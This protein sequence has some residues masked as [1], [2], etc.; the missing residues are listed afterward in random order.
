MKKIVVVIFLVI[1]SQMLSQASLNMSL[2]FQWED[3]SITRT[4]LHS[5]AYNEVWGYAA[6]G[7]EYA[8]IGSTRGTHIFDVTDP[9]N[10]VEV[11]FIWGK[12]TGSQI[13]HRDYHDYKGY[14]YAVSDEGNASLQIMD[15]SY[16]PDSVSVV[17]D[18][19]LP[20]KRA[21]NIFIDSA[22][23][24]MYVCGGENRFDVYD[25][26]NPLVPTLLK[27]GHL[28]V[29]WWSTTVGQG[30]YVHDVYVRNDTAWCNAG[31]GLYVVDFTNMATPVLLSG[32]TTYPDA[33]YNHSGWLNDAGTIY[34]MADETHGKK[35][36]IMDVSNPTDIQFIDTIGSD[37]TFNSIPHNLIFKGNYL[38]V[39]FYYDGLYIWDLTNP[40][41]PILTGF[42]DTSDELNF[43]AYRGNW[44][45]YPF[46]P[47]GIVLASDMQRGLFVFDAS[48]ATDVTEVVKE[49]RFKVFPN[50]FQGEI[51]V[52]GLAGFN[53]TYQAT[54]MDVSGKVIV[55]KQIN[56]TFLSQQQLAV[57]ANLPQGV[58]FLTI[59]NQKFNQSI[60]LVKQ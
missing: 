45:V 54:L 34:A 35:V 43:N 8:I 60:K 25:L 48:Y 11:D 9:V 44:G 30:G 24:K 37:I 46:L 15:L 56:N 49:N 26:T 18:S 32:L 22:T 21:H 41:N 13:V 12:D 42:Y 33:G 38:Y 55:S 58:Y 40:S 27:R 29:S 19:N 51:N 7:K 14:L 28:D 47:S 10:A 4:S 52:M 20:F 2:L 1:S 50:P 59:A 31:N 17:F 16:L 53:E 3:S 57:P 5:N 36:K 23:D 6:N 39:S